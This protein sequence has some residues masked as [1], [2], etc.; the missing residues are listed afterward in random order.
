MGPSV[1]TTFAVAMSSSSFTLS[2]TTA[3]PLP[4]AALKRIP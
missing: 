3:L 1:E 2:A 4:S